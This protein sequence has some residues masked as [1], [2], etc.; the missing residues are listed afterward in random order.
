MNR[1]RTREKAHVYYLHL[2]CRPK[3][4]E[5][6]HV[7]HLVTFALEEERVEHHLTPMIALSERGAFGV[8]KS[9][10]RNGTC[11]YIFN[12]DGRGRPTRQKGLQPKR[13]T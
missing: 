2:V 6:H 10:R 13:I 5:P 11:E 9:S 8:M 4:Q 1:L 12:R 3:D 7:I